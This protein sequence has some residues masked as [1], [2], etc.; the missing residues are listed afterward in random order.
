MRK[1]LNWRS[2]AVPKLSSV[3]TNWQKCLHYFL[4]S[5][6][7]L[8]YKIGTKMVYV[9]YRTLLIMFCVLKYYYVDFNG[10]FCTLYYHKVF[11]Y[12]LGSALSL[13]VL[14]GGEIVPFVSTTLV[15]CIHGR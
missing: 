3:H 2:S 10:M 12:Y 15:S 14:H 6:N 7:V 8:N 13:L 4:L 1:C 9:A 11:Y 5:E